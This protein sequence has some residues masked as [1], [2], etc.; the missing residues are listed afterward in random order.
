MNPDS[1][2]PGRIGAGDSVAGYHTLAAGQLSRE[3]APERLAK[4]L[5]RHRAP[6]MLLARPAVDRR[7]QGQGV[8][9][10]LLKDA[11]QRTVR[12]AKGRAADCF[13]GMKRSRPA[14]VDTPGNGSSR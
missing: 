1:L 14:F 10:A 11:L 12:A 7:R 8:G 9:K 3:D 2:M 4:D 6:I 13:Q 5:T